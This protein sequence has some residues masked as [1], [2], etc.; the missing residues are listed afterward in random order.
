MNDSGMTL[1]NA[2][3][4]VAQGE[5]STLTPFIR[6]L[7]NE[8]S[9]NTTFIEAIERFRLRLGT[10]LQTGASI[11]LPRPAKQGVT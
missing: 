2:I 7:D 10:P 9:W 3:H 6:R 1:P 8:M 5:Y 11:S 4:L